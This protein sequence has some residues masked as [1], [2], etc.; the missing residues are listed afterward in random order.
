MMHPGFLVEMSRTGCLASA[1]VGSGLR[2][3]GKF[4]VLHALPPYSV[5]HNDHLFFSIISLLLITSY[6]K[7]HRIIIEELK[8]HEET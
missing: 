7:L 1:R 5:L 8:Q 4:A 3:S 2:R 6:L